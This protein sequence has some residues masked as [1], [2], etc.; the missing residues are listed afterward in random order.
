MLL[1]HPMLDPY[2]CALRVLS[3]LSDSNV[4]KLEWDR[5]RLLDFLVAFPHTLRKMRLPR[6]Y[7]SK[8][9]V[10]RAV[11]EPYESLPNTT[12]LF[13]QISEIQTA[14]I[15]LLAAAELIRNDLIEHEVIHMTRNVDE[16]HEALATAMQELRYRSDPWYAFVTECLVAYPLNGRG[17]L[18]ERTGLMEHR[19][20]VD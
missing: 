13:Y 10:L 15:R 6:E 9:S 20:D 17:G 7:L 4:R 1:Y 12:R 19:H 5:L 3:L 2:H 16:Q 11:P 18:K 14:G 8:R